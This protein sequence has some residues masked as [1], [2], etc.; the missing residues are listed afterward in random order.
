MIYDLNI[1]AIIIDTILF[2]YT[3]A[4]LTEFYDFVCLCQLFPDDDLVEVE[5][6]RKGISDLFMQFLHLPVTATKSIHIEE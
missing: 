3:R 4:C 2:K 6:R 5:T 1:L